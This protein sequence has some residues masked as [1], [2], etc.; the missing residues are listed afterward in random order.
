MKEPLVKRLAEKK[1]LM[2][3]ELPAAAQ[4]IHQLV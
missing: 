4:C 2:N 1:K 3:T